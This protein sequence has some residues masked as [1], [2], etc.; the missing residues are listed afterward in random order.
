VDHLLTG[1]IV[2]SYLIAPLSLVAA[3]VVLVGLWRSRPNRK[4]E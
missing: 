1:L 4:P 2:L 3:V